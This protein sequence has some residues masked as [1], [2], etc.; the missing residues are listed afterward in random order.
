MVTKGIVLGHK[1][2]AAGLEVN[3]A[4]IVVT[5]T[6]RSPTTVKGIRSFLGHVV[7]TE[8]SLRNFQKSPDHCVDYWKKM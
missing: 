6:L 5:K 2:Y 7:F 1:I 3:Q 8:D 4:K